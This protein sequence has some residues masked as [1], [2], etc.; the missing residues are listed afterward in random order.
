MRHRLDDASFRVIE[1]DVEDF[2]RHWPSPKMIWIE[3]L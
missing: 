2:R 1:W 3:T